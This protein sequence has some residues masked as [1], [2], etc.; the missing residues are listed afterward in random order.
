MVPAALAAGIL[1]AFGAASSQAAA[2][3][4]SATA[5]STKVVRIAAFALGPNSFDDA[6]VTGIK[7]ALRAAPKGS[8]VTY[9][10]STTPTA[11]LQQVEDAVT[12]GRYNAILINPINQTTIIPAV[13]EAVAAHIKVVA[14]NDPIG[15]AL[16]TLA[17]QVKGVVGTALVTPDTQAQHGVRAILD[18]CA[19]V[20]DC[21]VGFLNITGTTPFDLAYARAFKAMTTAH[22]NIHVVDTQPTGLVE[23]T[24]LSATRTM[25]LANPSINVISSVGDQAAAGAYKALVGTSAAGH[26]KIIGAG[27]S[28][29]GVAGV[30]S[31]EWFATALLLPRDEGAAAGKMAVQAVEG[32]KVA[33][34]EVDVLA[35]T[36]YPV[37]MTKNN[38]SKF[39]GFKPQ[40]TS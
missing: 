16:N 37:V 33:P 40:W 34:D 20:S 10:P 24:A 21:N 32:K 28:N 30:R 13:K 3:K 12:T 17:P 4:L 18:A 36:K 27:A 29:V 11:Q 26:V 19:G 8:S 9:F 22:T 35:A 15:P 38:L 2:A 25:M 23:A 6:E 39:K 7:S 1:T 31:G 14:F 5:A